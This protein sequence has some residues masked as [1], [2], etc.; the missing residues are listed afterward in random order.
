MARR[1]IVI[2]DVAEE[3][4]GVAQALTLLTDHGFKAYQLSTI[5]NQPAYSDY[6]SPAFVSV[7]ADLPSVSP[8]DR[9][10]L[11]TLL[12]Q[13]TLLEDELRKYRTLLENSGDIIYALDFGGSISFV[14]SNV[15]QI[16]GYQPDEILGRNFLS[17]LPPDQHVLAVRAFGEQLTQPRSNTFRTDLLKKDG[18]WLSVEI[19][20][21]AY[22]ENDVPMLQ[23]GL[24]H[25]ITVRKEMEA[26][27]FQ[28]NCEL[29]ELY[30]NLNNTVRELR[31]ANQHLDDATRHKSEFLANMSHELRTPLNAII[32][33]SEVLYDQTFGP[34]SDK[35]R[36]FVDNILNSGKHLLALVNDVL[37]LSKVEAGKMKLTL[38][39]LRPL[40]IINE[41]LLNLTPLAEKKQ[42]VFKTEADAALPL[43]TADRGK[44]KQIL[45]NIYSNAIKFTPEGGVV[46]T[47]TQVIEQAGDDYLAIAI[48]DTG[49]GIRPTDQERIFEEFQM[50]DSTL[51]KKQQ[52]TGLGL[53]LCRKL[54]QMH[55]GT[56]IVAS[57]LGVGSTFVVTLP[58]KPPVNK[59]A[60][61]APAVRQVE[62]WQTTLQTTLNASQDD[63]VLIVE[64][65]DKSAELLELY[66]SQGGYRVERSRSG[67]EALQKARTM[68]PALITL[69]I[70]LPHKNG[71][72]VL[73]ELKAAPETAD[74]P[75]LIVSIMDNREIG[76]QL[77]AVASFVKPVQRDEFLHK[78]TELKTK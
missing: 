76:F 65:D 1:I 19:S 14:T 3:G 32:G 5:F 56:I 75:V 13:K 72:D 66:V 41:S 12:N 37:D 58:L 4:D 46:E 21:R 24:V 77:G 59:P 10:T 57:E 8:E 2:E 39:E 78:V 68:H 61:I 49:I 54:T 71:W 18:S 27:V 26:E 50:V 73:R 47:T 36:R 17:L 38:E 44:L 48:R 7:A 62:G 29:R 45:Y 28:R 31:Q 70:L 20:A 25:D 64:D 51:S 42:I 40:D 55:G 11:E 34:L 9:A 69:D 74:I 35:Q 53:A 22:Y 63:L 16:L 15:Q 23:I 6:P 30:N 43:L 52:G 60:V 33:F 67:E